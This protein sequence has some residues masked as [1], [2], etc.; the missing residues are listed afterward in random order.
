MLQTDIITNLQ[1]YKNLSIGCSVTNNETPYWSND[2]LS[3][4]G[5]FLSNL[6]DMTSFLL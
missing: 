6:N 2:I 1:D 3:G 5:C 4:A